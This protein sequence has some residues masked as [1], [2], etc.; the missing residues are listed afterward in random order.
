VL[1]LAVRH[2]EARAPAH[3]GL[4]LVERIGVD[5]EGRAELRAKSAERRLGRARAAEAPRLEPAGALAEGHEHLEGCSRPARAGAG[6]AEVLR[7][8]PAAA[9]NR[10]PGFRDAA[11][12]RSDDVR[13]SR[14]VVSARNDVIL[15]SSEDVSPSTDVV[16]RTRGAI[17]SSEDGGNVERHVQFVAVNA[18]WGLT[19]PLDSP[20]GER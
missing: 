17:S 2:L 3:A 14:D 19:M 8:Q 6:E 16:L 11:R 18:P 15:R 10:V 12:R 7:V 5:A 20:Q 4:E 1:V 9:T 13:G